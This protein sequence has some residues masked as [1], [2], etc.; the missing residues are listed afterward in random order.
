MKEFKNLKHILKT[1]TEKVDVNYTRFKGIGPVSDRDFLLV[2]RYLRVDNKFYA[3][4]SSCD[5]PYPEVK[6]V[7][8]G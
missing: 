6:D 8:R 4:S 5:Y 7:V 1:P 2:E 3:V